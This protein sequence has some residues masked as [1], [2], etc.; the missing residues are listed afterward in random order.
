MKVRNGLSQRNRVKNWQ[1]EK[2]WF[3]SHLFFQKV[4][5]AVVWRLTEERYK[6]FKFC[7]HQVLICPLRYKSSNVLKLAGCSAHTCNITKMVCGV[8]NVTNTSFEE[9]QWAQVFKVVLR[10]TRIRPALWPHPASNQICLYVFCMATLDPSCT[11]NIGQSS[12]HKQSCD[13]WKKELE[14][15]LNSGCYIVPAQ[16][17]NH[18]MMCHF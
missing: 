9:H 2:I 11:L 15:H 14:R 13:K 12:L 6:S 8:N 16:Q 18:G 10:R 4:T 7:I 5:K 3:T 17:A 1:T